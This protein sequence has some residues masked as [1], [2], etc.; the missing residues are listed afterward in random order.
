MSVIRVLS[1]WYFPW[2]IQVSVVVSLV[3]RVTSVIASLCSLISTRCDPHSGPLVL[4]HV[5]V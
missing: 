3:T 1:D 2:A 4:F 5:T